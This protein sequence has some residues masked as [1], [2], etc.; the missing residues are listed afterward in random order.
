MA[1]IS[2]I[3]PR[4]TE[5]IRK[6]IADYIQEYRKDHAILL[7]VRKSLEGKEGRKLNR[8]VLKIIQA[9]FPDSS[10]SWKE[11]WDK[12][13][14]E[15]YPP[16]NYRDTTQVYIGSVT[17]TDGFSLAWF[18]SHYV[19]V[20]TVSNIERGKDLQMT[21]DSSIIPDL[22]ERWNAGIEVLQGVNKEAELYN[23]GYKIDLKD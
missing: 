17:D 12:R 3:K 15:I 23:L 13:Y 21:L 2:N 6:E 18:D 10:I 1:Y 5:Q 16:M 20:R 8:N 7:R 9:A 11:D 19:N 22:V 14:V 4:S